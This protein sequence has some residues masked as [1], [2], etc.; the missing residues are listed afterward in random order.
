ML[1]EGGVPKPTGT[2]RIALTQPKYL[3]HKEC[4]S[5]LAR[6]STLLP[7]GGERSSRSFR[8]PDGSL[9]RGT[10]RK[11][12]GVGMLEMSR[13][14]RGGPMLEM[15]THKN[16]QRPTQ[17]PPYFVRGVVSPA[18]IIDTIIFNLVQSVPI[19]GNGG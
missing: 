15:N 13:T 6:A 11:S 1:S 2:D 4:S 8:D 17:S 19:I 7:I 18:L 3:C 10:T 9:M 12:R 14:R 5:E 16:T